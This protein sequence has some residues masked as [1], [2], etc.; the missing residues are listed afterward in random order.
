MRRRFGSANTSNVVILIEY[1]S[2]YI[3]DPLSTPLLTINNTP[4]SPQHDSPISRYPLH[5]TPKR[6]LIS[7]CPP[8]VG[9]ETRE[10]LGHK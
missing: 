5:L 4:P 6:R 10:R 2:G 3:T 1:H 7:P 8:H 9:V